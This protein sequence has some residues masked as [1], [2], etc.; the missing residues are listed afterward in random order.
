[1][2]VQAH[3]DHAPSASAKGLTTDTAVADRYCGGSSA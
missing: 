1:M 3:D 2:P